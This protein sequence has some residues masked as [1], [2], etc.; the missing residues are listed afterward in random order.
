MSCQVTHI[1]YIIHHDFDNLS[2]M[3]IKTDRFHLLNDPDG[4]STRHSR[5]PIRCQIDFNL[6]LSAR[7]I[8]DNGPVRIFSFRHVTITDVYTC[9]HLDLFLDSHT[10]RYGH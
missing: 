4:S 5:Q 9:M 7:V 6:I 1:S 2:E 8:T 10:F 3:F